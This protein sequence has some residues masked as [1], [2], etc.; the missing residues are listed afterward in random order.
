LEHCEFSCGSN[1]FGSYGQH[2]VFVAITVSLSLVG[3]V[4]WGTLVESTLPFVVRLFNL[5][6]ASSSAPLVATIVDVTGLVIY[7]SIVGFVLCGTL[8]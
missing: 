7:F 1:F 3:V 5:D 8:L 2:Y 6:P 4:L